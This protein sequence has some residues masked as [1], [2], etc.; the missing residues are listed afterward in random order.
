MYEY[1]SGTYTTNI[2]CIK[3]YGTLSGGSGRSETVSQIDVRKC[4]FTGFLSGYTNGDNGW[5]ITFHSCGWD[6]YVNCI[7]LY[8]ALNSA[9]RI[10]FRDCVMQNGGVVFQ[11]YGWTGGVKFDTCSMDYN[12]GGEFINRGGN[13]FVNNCHIENRGRIHPVCICSETTSIGKAKIINT[14]FV[15]FGINGATVNMFEATR[16]QN[17]VLEDNIY[18]WAEN[19]T[20]GVIATRNLRLTNAIGVVQTRAWIGG[21]EEGRTPMF[22]QG[23]IKA[24]PPAF[25]LHS[26]TGNI[27]ISRAGTNNTALTI[28]TIDTVAQ[29][30]SFTIT[31]PITDHGDYRFLSWLSVF[32][33][34]ILAANCAL[35][36]YFSNDNGVIMD[37]VGSTFTF[38]NGTGTIAPAT[39]EIYLDYGYAS[40]VF[41]FY[42]TPMVSTD[43]IV[44]DSIG[45]ICF[46]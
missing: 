16:K 27:T 43:L 9:E 19:E 24:A 6:K 34:C 26:S 36:V 37:Q 4:R 31:A 1:A 17:I 14:I 7:T 15:N 45:G 41:Y 13:F 30:K 29:N 28:R 40:L 38:G 2:N 12:S 21:G 35:T 5:G 25:L 11:N 46:S 20:T 42:L 18:N 3:H 23:L 8:T 44:I 32:S 33:Q 22:A 39:H 10:T